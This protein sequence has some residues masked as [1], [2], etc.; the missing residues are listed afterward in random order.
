MNHSQYKL[1]SFHQLILNIKDTLIIFAK[2]FG[3]VFN[4]RG[5]VILFF[6][7]SILY[8]ALYCSLYRNETLV[9]V[10]IAVVDGSRSLRSTELLRHVDATRDVKIVSTYATIDEAKKAFDNREVHG[11]IYIPADFNKKLSNGEQ[12]TISTYS[13]MSSFMYYRAMMMAT[14]YS[15]LDMGKQ[16]QVE[17]LNAQGFT[18]ESATVISNPIPYEAVILYNEGAGFASFLMPAILIL[19]IHQTLFFGIGMIAGTSREENR[20]HELVSSKV[21]RGGTFKVVIGKSA[22]YFLIYGLL[23]VYI[24]GFI[25]H[26]FNLP[27]IGNPVDLMILMVPFLLATIFFSM[28]VSVFLP[29]RETGLI[30]LMF[31]S[32]ILLFLSGIS[33]PRSNISGFWQA[34]SWI[35]PSTHGI[36]GYVKINTMG[37]N[38]HTISLEYLSLWGQ[39][40]V[41]FLT[42]TW[43]YRWQIKKSSKKYQKESKEETELITK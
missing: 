40:A 24:L 1:F 43:A 7:A 27:H 31:F 19:I 13:D 9:D 17:R 21:H 39:T 25:P 16:I 4:D 10:P 22:C 23:S 2:E 34:F 32:L 6:V 41:Y 18:G 37:A 29:N 14:N 20:F 5:V 12:A 28:T 33:W 8:P 11:L 3:S 30:I 42:A 26:A 38:I 35:F 15:I 36:Q